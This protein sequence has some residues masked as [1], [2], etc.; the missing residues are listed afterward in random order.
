MSSLR[1]TIWHALRV[2]F[3]RREQEA[4]ITPEFC[5]AWTNSH[6]ILRG[7]SST[8]CQEAYRELRQT[9]KAKFP[10]ASD[11][12]VERHE[13]RLMQCLI[14]DLFK[15]RLTLEKEWL[16]LTPELETHIEALEGLETTKRTL[17]AAAEQRLH[18]RGRLVEWENFVRE[19][20]EVGTAIDELIKEPMPPNPPPMGVWISPTPLF[21]FSFWIGDDYRTALREHTSGLVEQAK[22]LCEEMQK[23]ERAV[24]EWHD[25]IETAQQRLERFKWRWSE[26]FEDVTRALFEETI[27]ASG[28]AA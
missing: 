15:N 11:V 18:E 6:Y 1:D 23:Y 9:V 8:D 21:R 16:L 2:V 12:E 10:D 14:Q 24:K 20:K 7:L 17:L 27:Y 26:W 19:W 4:I 5:T 13:N 28:G 22:D 25:Y 3:G